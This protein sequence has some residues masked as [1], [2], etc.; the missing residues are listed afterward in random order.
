MTPHSP[1]FADAL[2]AVSA[3]L[4]PAD[5]VER[6]PLPDTDAHVT[7]TLWSRGEAACLMLRTYSDAP[8]VVMRAE[9]PDGTART[10]VTIGEHTVRDAAAWLG[11]E[12]PRPSPLG[13]DANGSPVEAA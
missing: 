4:G 13:Y 3:L 6:K 9:L 12:V 10:W 2:A 11:W 7:V 5:G 8:D 1:A